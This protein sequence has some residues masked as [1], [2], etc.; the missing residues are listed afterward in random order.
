MNEVP[1]VL[2]RTYYN[3]TESK[4]LKLENTTFANSLA[5]RGVNSFSKEDLL[6]CSR[7]ELFGPGNS[8]LPAPNMLMI[9]RII[10]ISSEGGANNKGFIEA[11][12]DINPDLWFFGCHFPGDPVMPGCLG[13]D[14]MW[15]LVGFFLGWRGGQGRVWRACPRCAC[16]YRQPTVGPQRMGWHVHPY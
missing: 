1:A 15:Q 5:A 14:A 7:G 9:D 3:Y 10:A 2:V 11:E 4:D 16:L 6:A 13:L 8:Q 12:L